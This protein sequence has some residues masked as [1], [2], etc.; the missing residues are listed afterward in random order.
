MAVTHSTA[1]RNAAANAV[2]ALLNVGGA[3]SLVFMTTGLSVLATLALSA[4]AAPGA[5]SGSSTFNAITNATATGTGTATVFQLQNNAAALVITGSVGNGS[6]GDI[7][8]SSNVITSGDTV[9]VTSLVYN[10][11]P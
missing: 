1:A 9:S 10:A 3:G 8:M 4:T 7:N 5:S 2:L 11:M 6:G